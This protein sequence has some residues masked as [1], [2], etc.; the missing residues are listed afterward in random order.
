MR[1]DGGGGRVGDVV[2]I[3]AIFI[4]IDYVWTDE[5][6]LRLNPPEDGDKAIKNVQAVD[7]VMRILNSICLHMLMVPSKLQWCHVT[8]DWSKTF[9]RHEEFERLN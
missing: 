9:N 6:D 8:V 1:K 4:G 7:T 3:Y 5:A 2:P